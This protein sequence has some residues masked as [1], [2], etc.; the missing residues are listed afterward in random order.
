MDICN[1][2]AGGMIE[3]D[4]GSILWVVNPNGTIWRWTIIFPTPQEQ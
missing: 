4:M 3:N 2:Y 1:I